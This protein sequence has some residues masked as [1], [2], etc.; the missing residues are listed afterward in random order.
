[1][2]TEIRERRF[3]GIG[4]GWE[5]SVGDGPTVVMVLHRRTG[6]VSLSVSSAGRDDS[7]CSFDLSAAEAAALAGLLLGARLVT[8]VERKDG[9]VLVSYAGSGG[10]GIKG[11]TGAPKATETGGGGA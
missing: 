4:P 11:A 6:G 2:E 3:P 9:S 8:E 5:L 1:M 7:E 10:V